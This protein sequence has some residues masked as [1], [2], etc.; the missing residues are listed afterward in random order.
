MIY[1]DILNKIQDNILLKKNV[2]V[3]GIGKKWTNNINI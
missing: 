3:I 2:V 1:K